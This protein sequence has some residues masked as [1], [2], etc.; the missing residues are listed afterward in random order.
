[1]RALVSGNDEPI[2]PFIDRIRE[3]PCSTI[4]VCGG[5]GS[6]F[7]VA[8][9]VIMMKA[10]LPVDATAAA[11]EIAVKFGDDK[12]FGAAGPSVAAAAAA[13]ATGGAAAASSGG[14]GKG[15][16]NGASTGSDAGRGT[17]WTQRLP[18]ARSFSFPGRVKSRDL[19]S[20][21]LGDGGDLDIRYLDQLVEVGQ[22]KAIAALCSRLLSSGLCGFSGA[23][24]G[25]CIRDL[26][27]VVEAGV[28]S[29]GGV[30]SSLYRAR[31][32]V[33]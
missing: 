33:H 13:A 4:L 22:S 21:T 15:K 8:D 28:V 32:G 10:F 9:R 11:K 26:V 3:L 16:Q 25:L 30:V 27:E 7:G 19:V 29:A 23:A 24:S 17:F 14:K 31:G 1:M 2:T 18:I 20:V 5:A 6:F 12:K